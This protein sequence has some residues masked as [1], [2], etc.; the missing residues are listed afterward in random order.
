MNDASDRPRSVWLLLGDKGGDSAQLRTLVRALGWPA[1]EKPLRFNAMYRLPNRLLGPSLASLRAADRAALTPPWPELVMCAGRRA[2]PVARWIKERSGGRTRLVSLGRP[3]GP[4]DA[5]DLVVAMP[6]YGVPPRGNVLQAGLPFNRLDPA[7]IALAADAW[8]GRAAA[9]P[10]P[11]LTLL[12]GGRARPLRFD[13]AVGS[14]I[15][16]G[17]DALARELGASVLAVTSRRTPADAAE[18]LLAE[19]RAPL[20][21]HRWHAGDT[22]NAYAGLVGLA[23]RLVVTGDS[24]SMLAEACRSGKP[25]TVAPVPLDGS[26]RERLPQ[27][28]LSAPPAALVGAL[29]AGGWIVLPRNIAAVWRPLADA[30]H[31]H[32]LGTPMASTTTPPDDL[33]AAVARVRALFP[34]DG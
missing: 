11:Y 12:I 10:A 19:I 24:A 32:V 9:L 34:S 21:A 26:W 6:Q 15:G 28:A 30:G 25:V 18:A 14:D 31:I 5:F 29:H 23:D 3:W 4:L 7:A 8:R 1:L 20:L 13:A 33:S 2:T 16:R 17:V 27:R 22:S